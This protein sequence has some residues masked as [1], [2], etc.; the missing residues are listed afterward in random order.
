MFLA[1]YPFLL[2]CLI[3]WRIIVCS[4]LLWLYVY[5]CN[6]SCFIS[7]FIWALSFSWWD[8]LKIHQFRLFS[9][10]HLLVLL[11]SFIFKSPYCIH[12]HFA[13]YYFHSFTNCGLCLFFFFLVPLDLKLFIWDSSCFLRYTC[14]LINFPLKPD[15]L[16]PISFGPLWFHFHLSWGLFWLPF[17]IALFTH[18]LFSSTLLSIYMFAFFPDFFL[19]LIS[20]FILLWLE[21]ILDMMVIFLIYWHLFDIWPSMLSI[22]EN[23]PCALE[24]NLYS[25]VFGCNVVYTSI[26]FIWSNHLRTIFPDWFS[27]W[28]IDLLI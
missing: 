24:K 20:I 4:S 7:E 18:W 26:K 21:K 5:G 28:V 12:F 2:G 3:C 16:H 13:F 9:K 6:F 15:W 23:V 1:I 8:W 17:F 22:L 19:E 11:I 25:A 14:I 10:K 27:I